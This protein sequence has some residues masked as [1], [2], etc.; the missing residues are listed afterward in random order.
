MTGTGGYAG[1]W[2]RLAAAAIDLLL[3]A[4][5][6]ALALYLVY[7][8]AYFTVARDRPLILG[9]AEMLINW[10]LPPVLVVACW[11]RLGGTPGK[12]LMGCLVLDAVSGRRLGV[13]RASLRC[14]GYLVSLLPLG[15]GFLWIAWA[16]R[17]QGFH[18]RLARTVVVLEDESRRCL[19]E[20]EEELR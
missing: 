12:L 2:R 9:P 7:G 14:L 13:A 15:L 8:P 18:D 11:V 4:V 16:P 10:V 20:L 3:F 6:S 1:F 19:E 17:K 5:L